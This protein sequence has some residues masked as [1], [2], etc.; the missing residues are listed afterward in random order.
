MSL[1]QN[2]RDKHPE[3]PNI[4]KPWTTEQENLLLKRVAEGKNHEEL[5]IEF[6]RTTG[7]ICSRLR[8]IACEMIGFG[9][10]IDYAMEKTKLSKEVI[11]ESLDKRSSAKERKVV[12]EE[13]K[14]VEKKETNEMKEMIDLMKE[15][16]DLLKKFVESVE[17]Q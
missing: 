14:I 7:G 15:I 16:R 5:S 17:V 13:K 4:G 8:Q 3:L 1:Y 10:S 11:Q 9:K 2:A 12:K 6:G